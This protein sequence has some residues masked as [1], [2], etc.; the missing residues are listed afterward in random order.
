[1]PNLPLLG[2]MPRFNDSPTTLAT[3]NQ[4]TTQFNTALAAM[5]DNLETANSALAIARLDVE[6]LFSEALAQPA[7]FGLTNVTDAAAPGLEPGD[8][9]VR[10]ESNRAECE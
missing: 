5:L 1:M 9:I 7:S 8:S 4:R 10:H 6:A 2:H 3:Y